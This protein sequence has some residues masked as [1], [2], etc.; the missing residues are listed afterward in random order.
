MHSKPRLV[1]TA[2]N[3]RTGFTLI[4]LMIVLVI[5]GV[6]LT[7][8]TIN[9]AGATT[10]AKITS[11]KASMKT[12]K[13]ALSIYQGEFSAYPPTGAG[14][15]ALMSMNPPLLK[16]DAAKDSWGHDFDYLSPTAGHA[17][18][19]RS[20]GPNGLPDDDDDIIEYPE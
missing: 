15:Q 20:R 9:F 8:V 19:L 14:L 13:G 2:R 6:L 10:K 16:K 7:I 11:T 18:E 3:A 4:E 1:A 5:I 12:I 17:Y